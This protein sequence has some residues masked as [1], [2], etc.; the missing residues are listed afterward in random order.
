MNEREE[1]AAEL[2]AI[3][4]TRYLPRNDEDALRR[5]AELLTQPT[6]SWT[7]EPPTE[8]T[9]LCLTRAPDGLIHV[10]E[11]VWRNGE[12]Y[13]ATPGSRGRHWSMKLVQMS[14]AHWCVL[15]ELSE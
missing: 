5:A 15:P 11:I 9:P 6:L 3:A 7:S 13:V 1:L 14:T 4:D 12:L 8:A 10:W 2:R